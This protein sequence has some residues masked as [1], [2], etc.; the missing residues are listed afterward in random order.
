M[1]NRFSFKQK[2]RK[3][4]NKFVFCFCF[5]NESKLERKTPLLAFSPFQKNGRKYQNFKI[6]TD[7]N[8]NVFYCIEHIFVYFFLHHHL[9]A[10]AST[11]PLGLPDLIKYICFQQTSDF[12][13]FFKRNKPQHF[14]S[15][16]KQKADNVTKHSLNCLISNAI[17]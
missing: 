5:Q 13:F 12:Y 11:S 8:K 1:E 16:C 10:P 6:F 4:S 2:Q 17:M 9:R 15:S 14:P 3:F 7:T